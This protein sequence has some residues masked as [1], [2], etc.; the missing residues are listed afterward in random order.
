MF[1]QVVL[2]A[3]SLPAL[4][5]VTA[6]ELPD[7]VAEAAKHC[8]ILRRAVEAGGLLV[9]AMTNTLDGLKGN[10][11]SVPLM[12]MENGCGSPCIDLR[13]VS[14][15]LAAAAKNADL[16]ILEGMGRALHT[17]FNARFK[18]EA[19]KAWLS[20]LL[21]MVKD[22]RLA[23]KLIKGNIYDCVCRYEYAPAS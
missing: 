18:C 13:Q 14:S 9:D 11:S 15:E 4:N 1:L 16:V 21:A 10:S 17:N 20:D 19:L 6:M 8:D 22:Q 2:V 12:V 23:E 3:N 5:D 7:I